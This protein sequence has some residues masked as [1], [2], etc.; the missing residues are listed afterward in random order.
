MTIDSSYFQHLLS[1]INAVG[2]ALSSEKN[3]QR[4]LEMILVN[5]KEL[6]S[7]DGGTLYLCT[8]EK[9]LE[10][11]IVHN[12]SLKIYMGG[13]SGKAVPF[14]PIKLIDESG[15]DNINNVAA[16]AAIK[17]KTFNI[18]DAYN[19]DEFDF[20]GMRR[21]D[22]K[23]GY[24]SKSFLTVPMSNHENELIGV[25]QLINA[26]DAE[27]G[28]IKVF[29]KLA[30]NVVES[31]AS[32][33]AIAI[34]NKQLIESQRQLFDAFL[35]LIAAA[36]D[37]KSPYTA[38]HCK[39]VPKLTNM[40]AEATCNIGYGP[41]KDFSMSKEDIYQLNVA[42]WLHDC[43]KITTPEAV[44]DKRTKLETIYDRIETVD[45]RFEILKR[46]AEIASLKK[47][48]K[49]FS[50]DTPAKDEMLV[51]KL[52][53]FND[54]QA[55]IQQCNIGSEEINIK[56]QQRIKEIAEYKWHD[57]DGNEKKLLSENEIYNLNIKKGTLN[58]EERE[59]INNH[60]VVTIK[61]LE[62]LPFPKYLNN[63]L[64]Y[65]AGHHE[66]MD[67]TGYPRGLTKEQMSVPARMMAIADIFEALTADDR[68][69]KKAMPLSRALNILGNM[70][71]NN[72]IDTDLFNVFMWQKV[73]QQYA[74]KFLTPQQCDDFNLSNIP[75]YSPPLK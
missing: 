13:T 63:V 59:I 36:I 9:T 68:P 55:F 2:I 58:D 17:N 70:T 31:L 3:H 39:R 7:A 18:P 33:A 51:K 43:G 19:N 53:Q 64:E 4:L 26:L 15:Q 21:V 62:R 48:L 29:S 52:Q 66:K 28:E 54:D 38:G 56:R 16:C 73:Y 60:I 45:M 41:Y 69:Y 71:L 25:L 1:K 27:T 24:H 14:Y 61:M 57:A 30:Q 75:G 34:S 74:D 44:I 35:K 20:S 23:T 46:D 50:S 32:Q 49:S 42:A 5:A 37:E 8:P 11:S 10:F 47:T 65:A 6:A 12:D 67:G 72:H 40:I 22:L